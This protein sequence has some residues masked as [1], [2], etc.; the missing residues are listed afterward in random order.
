M[1]PWQYLVAFKYLVGPRHRT[2]GLLILC[3][4]HSWQCQPMGLLRPLR[5]VL[6]CR[7]T[8]IYYGYVCLCTLVSLLLF[9]VL[10]W[11]SAQNRHLLSLCF[12][13]NMKLWVYVC[14]LQY[15]CA[16]RWN[17]V[18]FVTAGCLDNVAWSV[19]EKHVTHRLQPLV[20]WSWGDVTGEWDHG[21]IAVELPN[22]NQT[23]RRGL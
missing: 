12:V 15:S 17:K 4:T 1:D 10:F 16:L 21:E 5:A 23:F 7:C 18:P 13:I 14:T 3:G 20:C 9:L 11:F 19:Q 6:V 8:A 22:H 2:V